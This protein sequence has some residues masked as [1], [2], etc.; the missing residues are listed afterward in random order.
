MLRRCWWKLL[1]A[2]GLGAAA[3]CLGLSHN[4]S[5]FPHFLP[6]GNIIRT[7]GKPS[8]PSYFAN[9]DPHA[10]RLEVRPLQ[11]VSPVNRHHVLIATIYDAQGRPRRHRRVEWMLEGAGHIVEVDESGLFAGRGYKVDNRYAVSYTDYHEHCISRGNDDPNDD[12][13]IRP[14]QSWCV[15]SSPVEG[16]THV[17]V[18]APEIY[19]WDHNKVTVTTRWVDV[20]WSFPTAGASRAGG[21]HVFTT[22]IFR[23]TDHQ[24]LAGYQ[25]RYRLLDGGPP[26]SFLPSRAPEAVAVSNLDGTASAVLAQ[27]TFQP[28]VNRVGVEIVR[29]PDPN[30][31]SGAG[32][33]I[34]QTVVNM[35]WLG[36]QL[37]LTKTAPPTVALG[38]EVTFT[39]TV[40][41]TG[42]V[43][44]RSLTLRDI[45]PEG[46]QFVRAQPPPAVEGGQL[47]WTLGELPGGQ[48][49]TLQAIFQ[50]TRV[51]PVSNRAVVVSEE[52]MRAEA[53]AVTQVVQPQL[54]V[55]MT[56]PAAV[57]VGTPVVY[58]IT[59]RNPGTGP[60]TN[61]LLKAAFDE[62]LEHESRFNPVELPLGALA[63]GE[64]RRVTLTLMARKLGRLVTR[65]TATADGGLTDRAEHAVTVQDARLSLKL[66]GPAV[67]Y[68]DQSADWDIQV[69]NAGEVPLTGVVVRDLLPPELAFEGASA[70]GRLEGEQ[71]VW[72]V[73][74]LRPREQKLLQLTTRCTRLAPAAV[75]RAEATAEPGPSAHDEAAIEIRGLPAFRLKVV[76]QDDPVEVGG[77][78]MYRIEVTNEGS[79]PGNQVEVVAVVPAQMRLVAATGPA[80]HRLE[81]ERVVFEPLDALGPKQ[82]V[83]YTVEVQAQQP[84]DVRFRVELRSSTLSSPVLKE[85][86][87]TVF[88]PS[89][90]SPGGPAP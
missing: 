64:E 18:Y 30:A 90:G 49:R 37:T 83:S 31:P 73:G 2:V 70:G 80:R 32:L 44:T 68:V 85:E 5:Y 69:A 48:S 42:P 1:L 33:V 28:G 11:A 58:Q 20:E 72:S 50:S 84:G 24:P 3:G 23:H 74:E 27:E 38:Q 66:T 29:P 52:G 15:I 6:F 54:Q 59:A 46:L 16:D 75:N 12:F 79:L 82:T 35:E 87:T 76:D 51:G 8:G 25:V 40:A 57:A 17:T 60:A 78:T 21:Q 7:H 22:R 36:P 88:A 47:I 53:N 71:V 61:V 63:A 19:N 62:G 14:G 89:N 81:G 56:G 39:L 77:R 65:L 43:E 13:V 26:A 4:P 9:F 55:T 86:S 41:N 34:A 67:R 10:V 45:I